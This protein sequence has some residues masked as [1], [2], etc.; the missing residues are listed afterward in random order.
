MIWERYRNE[1]MVLLSLLLL[2]FALLYKSSQTSNN[3][4]NRTVTKYAVQEF[5]QIIA[6]KK[7]WADKN[8]VKKLDKLKKV[9]PE[10]KVQWKKKGKTLTAQFKGL[11]AKELNKVVTTILNLAVQI[12]VLKVKENHSSYDVEFKCKW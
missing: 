3:I 7:Q 1:L 9:V 6:H 10:S 11:N 2:I 5:K 8:I 4:E 12:Q